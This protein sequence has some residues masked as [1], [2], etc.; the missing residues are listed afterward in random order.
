MRDNPDHLTYER[1]MQICAES[2]Y[3]HYTQFA[4]GRDACV[5]RMIFTYAI[6]SDLT[7]YGHGD[8]WCYHT[9]GAAL[10]GL[11]RW[12]EADGEGEPS[13]W[14]RH[15]TTGRRRDNGDPAKEYMAL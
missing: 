1:G 2:G 8:R 14:H 5:T 10:L 15:P 3:T 13:G 9:L 12:M 11:G 6:L 4:N 7:E